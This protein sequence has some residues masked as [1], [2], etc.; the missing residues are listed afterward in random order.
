VT[1]YKT[2]TGI[3]IPKPGKVPP[4]GVRCAPEDEDRFEAGTV[5]DL[6]HLREETLGWLLAVGAVEE[7]TTEEPAPAAAPE[8]NEEQPAS[9]GAARRGGRS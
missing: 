2:L 4:V 7:T 1:L 3:T 9:S 6:A 8:P 5:V